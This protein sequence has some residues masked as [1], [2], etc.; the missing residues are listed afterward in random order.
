[1]PLERALAVHATVVAC[2]LNASVARSGLSAADG[3]SADDFTAL[4]PKLK[5]HFLET[6]CS[7]CEKAAAPPLSAAALA[8]MDA[9]YGLAGVKNAEMRLR[10]QKVCILHR[11]APIV[12]QVIA[13]LKEVGRMK[14]VR[15]LYR[16]LYAW[17]AQ[18][19]LAVATFKE[20]KENYHPICQTM[21]SKDLKLE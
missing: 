3:F 6:L 2:G 16:A 13:F 7:K 21:V 17:E 18:R 11:Y 4:A 1:M 5:I 14:F 10:W 8:K 12:P 20:W 9:L 19:E 15:P